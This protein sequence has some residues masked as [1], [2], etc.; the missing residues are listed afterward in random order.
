[1]NTNRLQTGIKPLY[2][3]IGVVILYALWFIIPMFFKE[4][5]PDAHGIVGITGAIKEWRAELIT[6]VV[7]AVIVTW[8]GWWKHI[9]FV[10]IEKGG[11]KFL[12]P[13]LLLIMLFLNTAW[14]L[15]DTGSWLMGY[16]SPL[17]LL[18]M[19]SVMLLL[20]FVEE[21]IFRGVLFYGLSTTFTPFFTVVGTAMIFGL[22]HFVNLFTGAAF[23]DTLY[24][25]IHAASMGFLYASLR[26]R[27]KAIW[28]LMILHALWDFS[29]FTLQ[30][31]IQPNVGAAATPVAAGLAISIPALVYGTFVYWRWSVQEDRKYLF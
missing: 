13:I 27:I 26:L 18:A 30:T 4:M 5:D 19:L 10:P 2:A 16:T 22:F 29:F 3:S 9:G 31:A 24:Q 1:M 25:V 15:D 8:L 28:P 20:G 21:G 7:L 17:Q 6:A 12:L 11:V 23:M 14:V